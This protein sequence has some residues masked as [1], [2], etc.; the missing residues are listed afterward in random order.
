MNDLVR[1]GLSRGNE[2]L[3]HAYLESIKMDNNKKSHLSEYLISTEVGPCLH[4]IEMI[5]RYHVICCDA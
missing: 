2:I 4:I 1:G 3:Q 5:S